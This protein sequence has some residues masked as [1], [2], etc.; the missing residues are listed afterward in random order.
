MS[1]LPAPYLFTTDEYLAFERTS[2]ERH[3]YLD[4]VIYAMAGESE[5]HGTLCTNLTG[6]LF[7]QLRGT[8]CRVFSKDMK[9]RSGPDRPGTREGLWSY[10]DLVVLCGEGRYHDTERDVLLNPQ[11]LIEV[12]SPSTEHFDRTRKWQRYQEWLPDLQDYALVEQARPLVEHYG[13]LGQ[14][15]TWQYRRLVGLDAT[16]E[17]ASI[18]CSMTLRDL[19]ERVTLPVEGEEPQG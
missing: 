5:T 2:D 17:L 7:A 12:L 11:V 19:Y 18:G 6:L 13:R 8:P 10:P 4:G 15:A 3:E 1:T 14:A 16:L 9:V